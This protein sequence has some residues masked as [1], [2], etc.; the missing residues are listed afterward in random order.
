L[1]NEKYRQRKLLVEQQYPQFSTAIPSFSES[2]SAS[3][4]IQVGM[5]WEKVIGKEVK[6]SDDK[7]LGEVESIATDWIEVKKGTL[8]KKHYF[9]PKMYA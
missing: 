2:E 4:Q 3:R 7:D 8:D 6:S 9:I 5:S 1:D